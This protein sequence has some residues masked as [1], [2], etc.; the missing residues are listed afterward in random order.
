VSSAGNRQSIC[1][2]KQQELLL[3][4][5]LL[6]E[7]EAI[8]AW[9]EWMSIVNFDQIDEGSYRLLPLLYHNLHAHNI[10]N[11]FVKRLK[12]VHRHTWYKNQITINTMAALL[13][14]FHDAGITTLILKGAALV[15]LYYKDYGLRPMNDF[16]ILVPTKEVQNAINV[17]RELNWTPRALSFK[18]L[19]ERRLSFKH[20]QAFDDASGQELDLHWHVLFTCLE[21]TADDDF[22]N[23]ATTTS[24]KDVPTLAL[25]A[26]DQ[27][28]H[29]CAHGAWWH[30]EPPVRW[31]ADAMVILNTTPDIDW[32]RLI[33]QARKCRLLLPIRETL[34]YLHDELGAPIPPAVLQILRSTP[35]SNAEQLEYKARA[36]PNDLRGPV[37]ELW[38]QYVQ[39][40]HSP[41][42]TSFVR[43]VGGFPRF[44][45]FSWGVE[46]L[47]QV[48][49][50][51]VSKGMRRMWKIAAWYR[52]RLV[53]MLWQK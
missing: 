29:V 35:V 27:L 30:P 45:Q 1:P 19:T 12:G 2:T 41:C 24:V 49:F 16:D 47:W 13:R 51:I 11:P 43:R 40:S 10:D 5:V 37:M 21:S 26:T 44:L 22:W 14:S 42:G 31:I 38:L 8:R 9:E 18:Q 34:G 52:S 15:L 7:T 32:D 53:P 20:A 25:C 4:A 23:S 3:R 50:Y 48:P 39:Y 46:H 33:E 28:L 36:C 6:R 17:L